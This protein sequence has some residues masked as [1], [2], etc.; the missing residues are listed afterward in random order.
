MGVSPGEAI[1]IGDHPKNDIQAPK[2][3]GM[4]AIWKKDEHW[5]CLDADGEIDGLSEVTGLVRRLN[6]ED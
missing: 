6:T 3:I 1:Y 4:K 5:S 2:A